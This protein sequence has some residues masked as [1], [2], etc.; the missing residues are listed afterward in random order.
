MWSHFSLQWSSGILDSEHQQWSEHFKMVLSD[1]RGQG[2]STRGLDEATSLAD[3]ERDIDAIVSKLGLERFILLGMSY[4]GKIAV[5]YALEHPERVLAL[6][7]WKYYDMLF[8]SPSVKSYNDVARTDWDLFTRMVPRLS[9]PEQD[10]SV[11]FSVHREAITQSDYLRQMAAL[12]AEPGE[13]ALANLQVP[14]LLLAP[15]GEI[16]MSGEDQARRAAAIIPNARLVQFDDAR[17]GLSTLDGTTPPAIRAIEQFLQDIGAGDGLSVAHGSSNLSGRE[18]E[19]LRL[20]ASGRSNRQ[21]ADELVISVNTVNRHVSNVFDK[22]GVANRTEA[23]VYARD[24][25][26]A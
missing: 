14:T 12:S 17:G 16:L 18:L 4:K 24:H 3:Y 25:G 21:I 2:L 6:V 22:T 11:V 1:S 19:V 9:W 23:S 8:Q 13:T 26:I 15:R 7:L 10:P 20:L 5:R